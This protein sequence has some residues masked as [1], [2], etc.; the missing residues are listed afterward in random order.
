MSVVDPT[1][2]IAQELTRAEAVIVDQN[3]QIQ[4]QQQQIAAQQLQIDGLNNTVNQMIQHIQHVAVPQHNP[5]PA[6]RVDRPTKPSTFDG[7]NLGMA[8]SWVLEL[9]Q[10]FRVVGMNNELSMVNFAAAQLRGMPATWWESIR[11]TVNTWEEFKEQF[12]K[13]YSPVRITDTA[14]MIIV[15]LRQTGSVQ[16]YI[17]EYQKYICYLPEWN[18]ENKIFF[19]RN[20]LRPW[21]YDKMNIKPKTTL[22]EDIS[23][24]LQIELEMEQRRRYKQGYTQDYKGKGNTNTKSF[25]RTQTYQAVSSSTNVKDNNNNNNNGRVDMELGH[26]DGSEEDNKQEDGEEEFTVCGITIPKDKK[27]YCMK[28]GLCFHCNQWGHRIRNCPE[29]KN[30]NNRKPNF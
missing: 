29:K 10:Y 4:T 15:H 11:T 14:R 8:R 12:K 5:V 3:R 21:I 23:H 7:S 22:L 20:G 13:V 2:A 28:K 30:T 26:I 6:P 25:N 19:F 18:E 1:Q 17:N 27:D 24:A 16:D 9:E